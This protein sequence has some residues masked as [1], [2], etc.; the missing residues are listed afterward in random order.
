MSENSSRAENGR[1]AVSDFVAG[2]PV[3]VSHGILSG[4]TGVIECISESSDRAIRVN[5]WPEGVYVVVV[6]DATRLEP[7]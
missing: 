6:N 4:A 1:W 7:A 2:Q 5:G 3:S